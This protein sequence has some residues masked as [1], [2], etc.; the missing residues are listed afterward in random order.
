MNTFRTSSAL[1][2]SLGLT[3][4]TATSA[5]ALVFIQTLGGPVNGDTGFNISINTV[6]D[7]F[8]VTRPAVTL[9]DFTFWGFGDTADADLDTTISWAIY[10]DNGGFADASNVL[11]SGTSAT[12]RIDTGLTSSNGTNILRVDGSFGVSVTLTTDTYWVS[13]GDG[14]ANDGTGAFWIHDNNGVNV[15]NGVDIDP[16]T[17][18]VTDPFNATG[19]NVGDMLFLIDGVDVPFETDATFGVVALLGILGLRKYVQW[20]A[21]HNQGDAAI[22]PET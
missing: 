12:S 11:A 16:N 7:D 15:L 3:L 2:L 8:T 9:T 19:I 21:E 13:F 22:D 4:L 10:Q 18:P 14:T 5:Q 20:R 6:A 1:L 17:R